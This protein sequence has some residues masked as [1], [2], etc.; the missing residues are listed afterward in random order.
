VVAKIRC[1]YGAT[2][3]KVDVTI[4]KKLMQ[5]KMQKWM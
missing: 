4:D 5:N 2:K 1:K 3:V